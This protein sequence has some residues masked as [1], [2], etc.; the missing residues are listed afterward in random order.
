[1]ELTKV[2]KETRMRLGWPCAL[3]VALLFGGAPAAFAE[4]E[5]EFDE[6]CT[7]GLAFGKEIKTDCSINAVIDG[8]TYC[9]G[10]E[11]AKVVFLKKPEEFLDKAAVFYMSK[12]QA[13]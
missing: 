11:E 9:F 3:T 5:G 10:N 6:L 2:A 7:M 4:T 8:R 13:Q 12:K 1:M